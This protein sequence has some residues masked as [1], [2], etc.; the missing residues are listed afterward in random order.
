MTVLEKISVFLSVSMRYSVSPVR[1]YHGRAVSCEN[2]NST[3]ISLCVPCLDIFVRTK[4]GNANM[5]G[6]KVPYREKIPVPEF[7]G[8]SVRAIIRL[9]L[10][11]GI[12][13]RWL[14]F[15]EVAR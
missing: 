9:G 6:L 10:G 15:G 7:E 14:W 11:H 12:Y 4:N 3:H 5:W 8:F 2:T 1:V 13:F